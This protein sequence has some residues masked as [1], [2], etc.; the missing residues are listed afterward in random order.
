MCVLSN[1]LWSGVYVIFWWLD[2]IVIMFFGGIGVLWNS[3]NCEIRDVS[4]I[5][6]LFIVY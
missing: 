3:I 2:N 4:L 5:L 6:I 1:K